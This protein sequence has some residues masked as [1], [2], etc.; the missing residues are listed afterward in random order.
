MP[1]SLSISN[2]CDFNEH[3]HFVSFIPIELKILCEKPWVS[4]PSIYFICKMGMINFISWVR[5]FPEVI[6]VNPLASTSHS[7]SFFLCLLFVLRVPQ[8]HS[9]AFWSWMRNQA[10]GC[11]VLRACPTPWLSVWGRD[12]AQQSASPLSLSDTPQLQ[13]NLT[14]RVCRKST[15]ADEDGRKEPELKT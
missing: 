3:I 14:R 2:I 15:R 13:Q 8:S 6:Y 5:V 9:P 7:L 10:P 1:L 12:T 11:A 4:P